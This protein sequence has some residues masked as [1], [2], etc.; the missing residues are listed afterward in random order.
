VDDTI[1][2][3][4]TCPPDYFAICGECA[5]EPATTGM[6]TATDNCD[7]SPV[8]TWEDDT[9][10]DPTT[11][12]WKVI[13][14]WTATDECGNISDPCTQEIVCVAP[15]CN[16]AVAAQGPGPGDNQFPGSNWFTYFE[17]N[18]SGTEASP[19]LYPIFTNETFRIGTLKVWDDNGSQLF[20]LFVP[21]EEPPG[22]EFFGFSVYH[23]QVEATAGALIDAVTNNSGNPVPGKCDDYNVELDEWELGNPDE[24][25]IVLDYDGNFIF[26]HS[27]FCYACD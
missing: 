18:G 10:V 25:V 23:I 19:S 16:T 22:C 27:I 8:I 14:T 24:D 21:D 11:C 15:T 20:L 6:A 9:I 17:Y 7:P 1:P 12:G 3:V 26:A 4:I 2:P 5:I 13:R